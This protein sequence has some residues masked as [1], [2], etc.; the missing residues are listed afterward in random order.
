[1]PNNLFR[2]T[3]FITSAVRPEQYPL[4]KGAEVAII[5]RSNSGK[6]SILNTICDCRKLAKTS[7]T[8]GRTRTIN[9]FE[10]A[11]DKRIVDLPGYGYARASAVEQQKWSTFIARYFSDR[12]SLRGV[13]IVMDARRPLMQ[14]DRQVIRWLKNI[15][16]HVL[17]NK[18]DKLKRGVAT[19]HLKETATAL[20]DFPATTQLFS[21]YN[22][23]GINEAKQK[24][25]EWLE[26]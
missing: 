11:K 12:Q 6:S 25:A 7:K 5:G 16:F 4:D 17:L 23:Q 26:I 21:V 20:A 24:L 19:R 8:P 14:T 13:V 9:F 18:T 3:R 2:Q 1:M 22:G 15:N 10:A